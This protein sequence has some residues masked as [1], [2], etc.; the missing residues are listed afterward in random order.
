MTA[1]IVSD[2]QRFIDYVTGKTTN[3][4]TYT[5]MNAR[6]QEHRRITGSDQE[7]PRGGSLGTQR[8]Y[9]MCGHIIVLLQVTLVNTNRLIS[10]WSSK[11]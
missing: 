7:D 6:K 3:G 9:D 10:K 4:T 11:Y 2:N 8:Q 5:G 1:G